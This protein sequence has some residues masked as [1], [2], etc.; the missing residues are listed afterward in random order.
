[1]LVVFAVNVTNFVIIV[2]VLIVVVGVI[3]VIVLIALIALIARWWGSRWGQR[4]V[5]SGGPTRRCPSSRPCCPTP[6][7]GSQ[8]PR[9][10]SAPS[11]TR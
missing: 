3:V 2:I 5:G 11:P 1:M 6:C 10:T 9:T 4:R 8:T 7:N